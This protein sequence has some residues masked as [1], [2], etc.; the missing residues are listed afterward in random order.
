LNT[1]PYRNRE[2]FHD[3]NDENPHYEVGKDPT[4][5]V[6]KLA[7]EE[8]SDSNECWRNYQEAK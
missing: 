6:L 3:A 5:N 4:P 1:P 7:R 2:E 8:K